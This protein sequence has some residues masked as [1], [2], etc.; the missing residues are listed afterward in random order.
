MDKEEFSIMGT[1]CQMFILTLE[2]ELDDKLLM[3]GQQGQC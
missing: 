2:K 3:L 1:D